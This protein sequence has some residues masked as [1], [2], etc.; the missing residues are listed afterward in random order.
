M[1]IAKL[2]PVPLPE[3]VSWFVI[4]TPRCDVKN[5]PSEQPWSKIF[6][7]KILQDFSFDEVKKTYIRNIR[8]CQTRSLVCAFMHVETG[9]HVGF[10]VDADNWPF[11]E[12]MQ[13]TTR[14]KMFSD[15]LGCWRAALK[16]L[17]PVSYYRL[18]PP[19]SIPIPLQA[20][21][22]QCKNFFLLCSCSQAQRNFYAWSPPGFSKFQ[23][24]SS[25]WW[26]IKYL[27]TPPPPFLPY[28]S[29]LVSSFKRSFVFI[30]LRS[31]RGRKLLMKISA[32]TLVSCVLF[33]F[34]QSWSEGCSLQ[35]LSKEKSQVR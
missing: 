5:Q 17:P 16:F 13:C 25:A 4:V 31:Q 8:I 6:P 19:P 11:S 9:L 27:D 34:F 10:V 1:L 35:K 23:Q 15:T 26:G 30:V 21:F 14:S 18:P 7:K 2:A 29:A 28:M 32:N 12:H 20:T 24:A 3:W 22:K 33:I